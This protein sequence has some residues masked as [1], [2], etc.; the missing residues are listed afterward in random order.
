M[1]TF[2]K[3]PDLG[4]EYDRTTIKFEVGEIVLDDIILEFEL[5]LKACGFGFKGSLQLVE[6]E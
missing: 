4:N 1:Y 3:T 6:D 2:I 5:F